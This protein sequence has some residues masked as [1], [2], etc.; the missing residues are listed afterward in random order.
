MEIHLSHLCYGMYCNPNLL[1]YKRGEG[2]PFGYVLIV[3]HHM[4]HVVYVICTHMIVR[5]L[6]DGARC[7]AYV[8]IPC[9][10]GDL[11]SE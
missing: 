9:N 7:D 4:S 1:V 6:G 8:M 5:W 3:V 10:F 2:D 11:F